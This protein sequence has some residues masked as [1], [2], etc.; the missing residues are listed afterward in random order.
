MNPATTDASRSRTVLLSETQPVRV[1]G[2]AA[3]PQAHAAVRAVRGM[4]RVFIAIG[5]VDLV[6]NVIPFAVGNPDWE[7][8]VLGPTLDGLPLLTIGLVGA[9]A[10]G[11]WRG[12]GWPLRV[13]AIV[14]WSLVTG[15]LAMIGLYALALPIVWKA[16][17]STGMQGPMMLAIA[18]TALLALCYPVLYGWLAVLAWRQARARK[19]R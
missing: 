16:A 12:D 19:V 13:H 15:L 10:A 6:L 14:L 17:A 9:V 8:G 4:A 1:Q 3:G 7:F 18:K 5:L 11:V 2:M